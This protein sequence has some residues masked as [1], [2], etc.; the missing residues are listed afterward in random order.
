MHNRKAVKLMG[1]FNFRFNLKTMKNRTEVHITKI[2]PYQICNKK[3]EIRSFSLT[4]IYAT[5]KHQTCL[6]NFQTEI[7]DNVYSFRFNL[8]TMNIRTKVHIMKIIPY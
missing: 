2:I 3:Y 6:S 4:H 8:K 5:R 1:T 7:S